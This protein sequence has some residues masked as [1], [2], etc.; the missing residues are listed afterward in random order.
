MKNTDNLLKTHKA[1]VTLESSRLIKLNRFTR[2]LRRMDKILKIY[3]MKDF[4]IY[5]F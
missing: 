4:I 2:S 1:R 5:D 3:G